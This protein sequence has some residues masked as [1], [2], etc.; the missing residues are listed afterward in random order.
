MLKTRKRK[1]LLEGFIEQLEDLAPPSART[2]AD[3]YVFHSDIERVAVI[4]IGTV[5]TNVLP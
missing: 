3:E 5:T 2:A 1:A 4:S